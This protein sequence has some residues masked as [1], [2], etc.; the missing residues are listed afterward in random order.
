[1]VTPDLV[2]D[3]QRPEAY[4]WRPSRVDLIE[5]H[6][7]WVFLAGDRVVKIKRPVRF[8]F[9]DHRRLERRHQSCR[10]E[11]RL[12][13]RLTDGVYLGVVPI[14]RARDG[15]QV[16]GEGEPVEWATLMR[17]L[18]AE[19]MLDQLLRTDAAPPDLAER[20]ASR[21]V[22][23]H[24]QVAPICPGDPRA[25][26]DSAT[27]I[28]T[29]NLNELE[30]FAGE[31][32]GAAQFGF[33][34]DAMRGFIA[35]HGALLRERAAAGWVRE[36]H[37]DLRCEH[38][39]L[40]ADGAVQIF[41][42]VEF[43][44]DVRCADVASDLAYL[45]MDLERLGAPAAAAS[46]LVL[47]RRAGVDL[48]DGLLQLY[49]A[50]RALVR[51]KIAG[52]DFSRG[53]TGAKARTAIKAADYLDMASAAALTVRPLLI[54]MTGLSGTGKSS[55][56]RRIA[57]ALG[58]RLYASDL[59]RKELAGIE[60]AAPAAWG[61]GIYRAEWSRATYDRL[62][63]LAAES[64]G[65]GMPV[66]LDAAFLT[67]AQREDA[68]AAA[69]RAGAPCLLVETVCASETVEERL[70]ARAAAGGSPSDATIEIF[71]HQQAMAAASPPAIPAGA[72]HVRI[73]TNGQP[74]VSLDPLFTRLAGE[75]V[76]IPEIREPGGT[77]PSGVA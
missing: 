24:R 30:P 77:P 62:F 13:R 12:N 16:D 25:V 50:H 1:M 3:L 76:V 35:A 44:I 39:C 59:V 64:L 15:Y 11:V 42:C 68:A 9:V 57:R 52:I 32:L 19:R 4:P 38:V 2:T 17:R 69:D 56:A 8:P 45:L 51:A 53:D 22:P 41:D 49:R 65:A 48:P 29:D 37:G 28:V 43:N 10:D 6:V 26:A 47:Y 20:L 33:V 61:E 66:V 40:E 60:G 5:T 74:P 72:W 54:A 34:R 7:S 63:A 71:R 75:G 31:P 18:P 67:S 27:G 23:F 46:L 36:G 21:L 14:V 70:A 73:D 55:V 58:A